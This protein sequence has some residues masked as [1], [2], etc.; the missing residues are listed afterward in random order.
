MS[1]IKIIR[2][3]KK[4]LDEVIK[5]IISFSP[6]IS[7]EMK[8]KEFEWF[9]DNNPYINE[10]SDYPIFIAVTS[11][12]KVIGVRGFFLLK[13]FYNNE[14]FLTLGPSSAYVDSEYRRFGVFHKLNLYAI[15][16]LQYEEN[17][18]IYLNLSSN[19]YSTPGYLKLG[20]QSI[21]LKSH[22]IYFNPF[23]LFKVER[24]LNMQNYFKG[25]QILIG[26]HVLDKLN[27]KDLFHYDKDRFSILRDPKYYNWRFNNPNKEFIKILLKDEENILAYLVV[28]INKDF[29]FNLYEF[30]YTDLK[31]LKILITFFLKIKKVRKISVWAPTLTIQ[32]LMFFKKLSFYSINPKVFKLFGK[33]KLPYLVRPNCENITSNDWHL[34]KKNITEERNWKLFY[35]DIDG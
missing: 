33:N 10:I 15:N 9:Y 1:D 7:T 19:K 16:A 8:I 25:F 23:Y 14:T 20:W 22:L 13:Y 29:T 21:N 4:Y 31:F 11:T 5:L 26:E 34:F 28:M 35:S 24:A 18:K 17:I 6:E 27:S 2:Y 3:N 12:D 32:E 30:Q